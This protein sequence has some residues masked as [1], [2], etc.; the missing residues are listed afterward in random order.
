MTIVL[1][2]RRSLL[3]QAQ[4]DRVGD[5]VQ[6]KLGLKSE[7]LLIETL[8]D[9][10][11][12]VTIDKIGGKGVFVK[13]VEDALV[14]GR[15]HGAVHSMKDVPY[16]MMDLFTISAIPERED[17]RDAFIG[18]APFADLKHGA[19][20]GT[21]SLRRKAQIKAIR[22]DIE[23]VPVRGN[24]QTRISKIEGENLD[25]IMLAAAG[26]KR[27]ELEHLVT[28]YFDPTEFVPAVGQGAIGVETLR[29]SE[30]D[31]IFRQLD[32]YEERVRIEAERSFMREMNGDCHTPIGAYSKLER[33]KLYMVGIFE[34]EGVLVKKDVYGHAED[35]IALGR[36]LAE[37]VKRG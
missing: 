5:L 4:A 23:V 22:P 24:I 16:E 19:K 20:I 11:L 37:L 1:A 35:Y 7:K 8:G 14:D 2:T 6:E 9:K 25:G 31:S 3:A 17:E 15:A 18:R 27:M 32:I 34:L 30:S 33:D 36:K 10:R 12:D 28:D 29:D 21:S 13:D 26:L